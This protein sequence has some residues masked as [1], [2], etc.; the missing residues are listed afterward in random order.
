M[1]Y[2]QLINYNYNYKPYDSIEAGA[3]KA[4]VDFCVDKDFKLEM[5]FEDEREQLNEFFDT[6]NQLKPFDLE[7]LSK[8]NKILIPDWR[9][10][11]LLTILEMQH[12][13][14]HVGWLT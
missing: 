13:G 3:I 12:E 2:P 6:F 1:K 8:A 9:G 11:G 4:F 14:G 10:G 7:Y 5:A